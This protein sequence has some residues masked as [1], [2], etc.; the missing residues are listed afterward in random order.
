MKRITVDL[1][2][3]SYPILIGPGLLESAGEQ[4]A[5]LAPTRIVIVTNETVGPL[6]L[7]RLERALAGI[8]PVS[9]VVLPDG[10]RYKDFRCVQ[11]VLDGLVA[12]GADRKSVI[13][14]LG[15]GVVG[16]IAGFAASIWMRGIRFVQVPTTLLS[17]VDSSVGGKTGVN[18]P[19]GKNLIGCFH[20][21]SA[22][23][24]DTKTLETL[25]A[26][27][28][29][30]GLGEIVKHGMLGNAAYFDLVE[31]RM[32]E[33]RALGHEAL[34]EVIAGS[35]ELKANVVSRDETEAG[36]RATL[37]LG[38]TFGHAVEKLTG[39]GTWLHGEAVGCGLVLAADLSR[40][41]GT[42]SQ[43]EEDRIAAAVAAA[44]LPVRIP[45]LPLAA[46]VEAMK[47]DKK[48]AGGRIRFITLEGIGR[49]TVR[50]VPPEI[51]RETLLWGGY[52]E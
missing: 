44:G 6:Y 31:S 23:I 13:L 50:E 42:L 2:N 10:E 15:G 40:R 33:I 9:A 7:E 41:L 47:G 28:I 45:G 35:C 49:S 46:A 22:V 51:L 14:A 25:P 19:A 21:P 26:R 37:N 30:A 34:A 48:S 52:T 36:V 12:A 27:E 32:G 38:H 1:G 18:L 5:P 24:A 17:Q 43:A 3:R 29:S 8:A 20:Q 16:D 39:F 11:M 4:V